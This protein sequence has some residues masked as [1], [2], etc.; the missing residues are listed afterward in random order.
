M[1][2]LILSLHVLEGSFKAADLADGQAVTT[3]GGTTLTVSVATSG[4][5]S[6]TAAGGGP[7]ATVIAADLMSCGG[8]LH[9]IDTALT[10]GAGTLPPVEDPP[11]VGLPDALTDPSVEDPFPSTPVPDE[12]AAGPLPA[13]P[14]LSP[15][16][17][18]PSV[19]TP[20]LDD[21]PT[22]AP[23]FNGPPAVEDPLADIPSVDP[24]FDDPVAVEDPPEDPPSVDPPFEDP[25][26]MGAPLNNPP[27][28]TPPV[29]APPISGNPGGCDSLLAVIESTA[30]LTNLKAAVLVRLLT[31]CRMPL[32]AEPHAW[33]NR[34]PGQPAHLVSA[35]G[36]QWRAVQHADLTS[37]RVAVAD[38]S[39][40][41]DPPSPTG[42]TICAPLLVVFEHSAALRSLVSC[43]PDFTS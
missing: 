29:D 12:P 8:V 1:Q 40:A 30:E 14:E 28:D 11:A 13:D 21:V 32:H 6:F 27:A 4:M 2:A 39:L 43:G 18:G 42:F 35:P 7:V 38:T 41:S 5:I 25:L 10:P 19:V 24:P 31:M 20:P 22:V 3:L 26:M 9:I 34:L 15:T 23:S 37:R 16:S 36:E 17:E 33:L